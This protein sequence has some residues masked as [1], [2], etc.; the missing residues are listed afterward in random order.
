LLVPADAPYLWTCRA[1][2]TSLPCRSC[3]AASMP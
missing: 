3:W 1:A 2:P